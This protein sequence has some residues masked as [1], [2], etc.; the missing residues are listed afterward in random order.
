[1]VVAVLMTASGWSHAHAARAAPQPKQPVLILRQVRHAGVTY[2]YKGNCL[3]FDPR[4]VPKH[5]RRHQDE[6][7]VL[8]NVLVLAMRPNGSWGKP[9]IRALVPTWRDRQ[10]MPHSVDVLLR[11][12]EFNDELEKTGAIHDRST[13]RRPENRHSVTTRFDIVA[14]LETGILDRQTAL[15]PYMR[16][17]LRHESLQRRF[18]QQCL[19]LKHAPCSEGDWPDAFV[20][21][22]WGLIERAA[23]RVQALK[24]R[25]EALPWERAS[26]GSPHDDW[27]EYSKGDPYAG[28][29]N[30]PVADTNLTLYHRPMFVLGDREQPEDQVGGFIP[31]SGLDP[32]ALEGLGIAERE[33]T[34]AIAK[35]ERVGRELFGEGR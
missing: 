6:Y 33:A 27:D 13:P 1:M 34:E 11:Q 25:A 21:Y 28:L 8:S 4:L 31:G 3:A 18:W 20:A 14:L 23:E 22:W 26:W 16:L 9:E 12:M 24:A 35:A 15:I 5:E 30:P 17:G 29:K 19:S 2:F 7:E 10:G 32:G